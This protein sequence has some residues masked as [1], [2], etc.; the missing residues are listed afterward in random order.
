LRGTTT[1]KAKQISAC[2]DRRASTDHDPRPLSRTVRRIST[3]DEVWCVFDHTASGA[4]IENT[5][6]LREQ[7]I[8]DPPL[9]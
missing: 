1:A 3:A 4:A 9:G 7:L 2:T 6:E 8:V 5:W